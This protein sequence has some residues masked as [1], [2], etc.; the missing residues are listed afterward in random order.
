LLAKP[1]TCSWEQQ[2]TS[3]ADCSKE[4][5]EDTKS[6]LKYTHS[7]GCID[8]AAQT[9]KTACASCLQGIVTSVQPGQVVELFYTLQILESV[10]RYVQ[11]PQR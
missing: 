9:R 11:V 6:F 2:V 10:P 3:A 7:I 5:I 8:K 1:R 4:N